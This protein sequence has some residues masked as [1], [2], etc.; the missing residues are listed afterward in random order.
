MFKLHK[1]NGWWHVDL[2]ING[3]RIRRA[4]GKRKK[5]EALEVA[6][7]IADLV[8]AEAYCSA[9]DSNLI[10]ALGAMLDDAQI[11]K[12][13]PQTIRFY[14]SKG[15]HLLR[16][17]GAGLKL[18]E[19]TASTVDSYIKQ[20]TDEGASSH[21]IKKELATL[22]KTL[23]LARR[24]GRYHLEPAAVI[25]R[26]S[27]NYVPR[28][29]FL[30]RPQVDRLLLAL[31]AHRRSWVEFIVCSGA[32]Y[33]EATKAQAG[34]VDLTE[35]AIVIRGTKTER[36]PRKVPNLR[37]VSDLAERCAGALPLAPWADGNCSRDM[38][39]ACERAEV[40]PTTCRDLRRTA[41]Q[42][43]R[44]R[45]APTATIAEFLGHSSTAMVERVYGRLE[46]ARLGE[47]MERAMAGAGMLDDC[48]R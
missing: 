44:E 42:W 14:E 11:H 8:S 17:L 9:N 24:H 36:A 20:R 32:R 13:S 29:H 38:R 33:T 21:T 31:P 12:L 41:A 25:P 27:P 3:K 35:G 22:S 1:R 34:D 30:T 2:H 45:G 26:Y 7:Q 37:H 48:S 39:A 46:G 28:R 43:L 4:T 6:K 23:K 19:I 40:P 16:I 18:S 47:V 10:R 5:R 15:R